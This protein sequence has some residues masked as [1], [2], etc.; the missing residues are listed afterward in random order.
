MTIAK[1]LGW[2]VI[3]IVI[4]WIGSGSLLAARWAQAVPGRRL[5]VVARAN[6]SEGVNGNFIK[7]T[8]TGACWLAVRS[9]DDR[10]MALAPAP[11]ESCQQE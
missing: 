7:D 11:L 9:R 3:G 1:R 4:G 2:L 6:L 10:D 5:M 8:R